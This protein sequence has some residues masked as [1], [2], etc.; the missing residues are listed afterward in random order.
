MP[1]STEEQEKTKGHIL[2]LTFSDY[3]TLNPEQPQAMKDL[4]ALDNPHHR[5]FFLLC[6][7]DLSAS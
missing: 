7:R 6:F 5:F 1:Q 2:K 3:D 4:T